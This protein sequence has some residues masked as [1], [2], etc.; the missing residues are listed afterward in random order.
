M[1]LIIPNYQ[2]IAGLKNKYFANYAGTTCGQILCDQLND[3]LVLAD[4][5]KDII[6]GEPPIL[7]GLSSCNQILKSQGIALNRFH[8][9]FISRMI[10]VLLQSQGYRLKLDKN[11]KPAKGVVNLH[12]VKAAQLFV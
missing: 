4:M 5:S 12:G 3:S 10:S 11:G 6:N 1:A 2:L 8:S 7:S 9:V